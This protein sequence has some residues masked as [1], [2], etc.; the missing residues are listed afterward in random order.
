VA[1]GFFDG[2]VDEVR[3]WD[4]ARTQAEIQSAMNQ[5]ITTPQPLWRAGASGKL[6]APAY[7]SAWEPRSTAR[8]WAPSPPTGRA[9]PAVRLR[10]GRRGGRDVG[11]L[12]GV[13][14]NPCHATAR[15]EW[16]LPRATR[17]TIEVLDL[18]GRCVATLAEGSSAQGATNRAERKRA[19]V[20][21]GLYMIR[22]ERPVSS[23]CGA[24]W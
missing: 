15:V 1:A 23:G 5:M 22:C 24:W 19:Y 16:T 17:V 21:T 12:L 2:V 4:V 10:R 8:S 18:Q 14:P 20:A 11:A 7:G 6:R 9:P 3:I 13:G